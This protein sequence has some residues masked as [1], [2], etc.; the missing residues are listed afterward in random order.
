MTDTLT[1][2]AQQLETKEQTQKEDKHY[3]HIINPVDNLWV[4][5]L[6]GRVLS[7]SEIVQYARDNRLEVL[8]LCGYRFVPIRN[9]EDV[10][11]TCPI[12]LDVAGM[13]M[14]NEGE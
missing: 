1:E 7:S 3:V 5:V 14:R 2:L 6:A 4:Q 12:C 11:G 13:L 8:C 10:N 9:P